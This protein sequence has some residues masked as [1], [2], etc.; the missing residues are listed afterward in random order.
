MQLQEMDDLQ[1]M[2]LPTPTTLER[3]KTSAHWRKRNKTALSW[4]RHP[5]TL[6]KI[7]RPSLSTQRKNC[8]CQS[9][10]RPA[11]RAGYVPGRV[12]RLLCRCVAL[13]CSVSLPKHR[14]VAYKRC[15]Q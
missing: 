7:L 4:D 3:T 10:Q 6:G 9:W 8:R 1:E 13:K 11:S 15:L 2:T 14:L 12:Y 5:C